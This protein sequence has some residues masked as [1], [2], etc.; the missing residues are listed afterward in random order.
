MKFNEGDKI[1]LVHGV[2]D[3]RRGAYGLLALI[4]ESEEGVY[5]FFSNRS[6]TLIKVLYVDSLGVWLMSRRLIR[7]HFQWLE[8]A[9][10]ITMLTPDQANTLCSGNNIT[11]IK[12]T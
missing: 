2:V 6:R 4:D 3:L 1:Y 5:Y 12:Q 9:R 8:R 7:G 11:F 10:S